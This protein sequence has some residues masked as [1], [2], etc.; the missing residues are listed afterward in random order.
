VEAT[1]TAIVKLN[2]NFT[3]KFLANLP[4]CSRYHTIFLRTEAQYPSSKYE[5]DQ[6]SKANHIIYKGPSD[7]DRAKD[8]IHR[9][10]VSELP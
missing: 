1:P 10:K 9:L 4:Q 5:K 7:V 6:S 3:Y 2:Q 8:S